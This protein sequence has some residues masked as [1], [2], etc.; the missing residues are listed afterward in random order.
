MPA[1]ESV[2]AGLGAGGVEGEG[3]GRVALAGLQDGTVVVIDL[4]G[5]GA[6]VG[7][8]V[9]R[10]LKVGWSGIEALAY[11]EG[12]EWV[13]AGTRDGTVAVF[14]LAGP[15]PA[16]PSAPLSPRLTF[17]RGSASVT[18]L[19][20]SPV[21]SLA[22]PAAEEGAAPSLLV[23]TSD[24]LPFRAVFDSG[25]EGV[26]VGEEFAGVECDRVVVAAGVAAGGNGKEVWVG[27]ADGRVR[28]YQG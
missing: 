6:E 25:L 23:G 20:F 22:A 28:R 11:D 17:T 1:P 3:L 8:G 7:G 19:A 18:S 26:R 21:P 9:V 2:R 5:R 4:G 27:A 10:T 12:T 24:G 15:P 16:D 14:S 13:A